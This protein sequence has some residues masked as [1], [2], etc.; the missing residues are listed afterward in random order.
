LTRGRVCN[1]FVQFAVTLRSTSRRIHDH[2]LLSHLRPYFTVP[3]ETLPTWWLGPCID[4]PQEED[5]YNRHN[6]TGHSRDTT[7]IADSFHCCD[8]SGNVAFVR[9]HGHEINEPFQSNGHLPIVTNVG[10]FHKCITMYDV[11]TCMKCL[12]PVRA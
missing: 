4:I 12:S 3:Y 1:L 2:I 9:Y 8:R 7:E 11:A 5:G 6:R 10:D